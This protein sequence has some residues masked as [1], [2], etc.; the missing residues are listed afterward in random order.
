MQDKRRCKSEHNNHQRRRHHRGP[1]SYSMHDSE[2]V[3]QE[4]KLVEG[5][6]FLDLGC[7]A[8]DY[9]FRAGQMVGD[10][11]LVFALD[12]WEGVIERLTEEATFQGLKN[13]KPMVAD[14]TGSLPIED[15]IIDVCFIATVLHAMDFEKNKKILF[16][17]IQR[18]LK[19]N[20]RLAII[21]CK[22]EDRPF[23]PSMQSRISPEELTAIATQF[24]FHQIAFSD[25]GYNYL[26]Q[27][28]VSC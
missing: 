11:G 2:F 6:F 18:V 19:P 21:E 8:G 12:I 20:G 13:I 24:G 25:L 15:S 22:K 9:A 28:A 26:I 23:G 3:F 4:L 27:F 7:G 5:D 1:S 14:I 17:E 16:N 10:S